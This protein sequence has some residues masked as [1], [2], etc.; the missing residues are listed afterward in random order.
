VT[1]TS[2]EP[3]TTPVTVV[4]VH[5]NGGGGRRFARLQPWIPDHVRIEAITLPGFDD[6][7][8]EPGTD[9]LAGLADALGRELERF[10]RPV[11][12]GHGIGGS[13]ALELTQ[14]RPELF[15]ALVL[16]APVGARL[17]TRWF[18]RLMRLPGAKPAVRR[19]IASAAMRPLWRRGFFTDPIDP[20]ALDEFF[21]A[22]RRCEAFEAMFDVITPG[23]FAGLHPVSLP[24]VI[25]WGARDRVLRAEQADDFRRV[26]PRATVEI[27]PDWDHFPMIERP[28]EYADA[29]AALAIR[30]TR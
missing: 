1:T 9:T 17:D 7:P 18:P 10:D 16:H 28:K 5:G 26:L 23:W 30:L 6:R 4:A 27:V 22:Y 21:E 13:F 24:S 8:G 19:A 25:W 2:A 12:L 20:V 14:R 29:L 3:V 11:V 15:G